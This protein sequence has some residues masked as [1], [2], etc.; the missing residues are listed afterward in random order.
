MREK[1]IWKK[2][3]S[4]NFFNVQLEM[5][6]MWMNLAMKRT[7]FSI[8]NFFVYLLQRQLRQRDR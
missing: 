8:L 7:N 4:E 6:R 5:E 3:K 2:K 1:K